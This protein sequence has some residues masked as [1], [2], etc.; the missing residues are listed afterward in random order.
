MRVAARVVA[1]AGA[2]TY[3]A[4]GVVWGARNA[5]LFGWVRD[6]RGLQLWLGIGAALLL[7]GFAMDGWGSRLRRATPLGPVALGALV[8]GA[9]LNLVSELVGFAIL[10]TLGLGAGLV[11]LAVTAF[12]AQLVPRPDRWLVAVSAVLSLTWN[13]ETSTAWFLAANGA[14]WLVLSAR[15]VGAGGRPGVPGP[16][17]PGLGPVPAG[18]R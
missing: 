13:T 15:L 10:G 14:V 18:G 6:A 11:L 8:T 2:V 12:R 1:V 3:A 17:T 4:T 16:R 7:T 5:G 9:A